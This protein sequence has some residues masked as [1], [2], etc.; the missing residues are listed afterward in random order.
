MFSS[1]SFHILLKNVEVLSGLSNIFVSPGVCVFGGRGHM[2][3]LV[4][5]CGMW[6]VCVCGVCGVFVVCVQCLCLVCVYGVGGVCVWC[7]YTVWCV[8]GVCLS[9]DLRTEKWGAPILLFSSFLSPHLSGV[10][11]DPRGQ[12]GPAHT[13]CV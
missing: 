8:Y 1:I 4:C 5:V 12:M 2:F 3:F 13:E 10:D 6:Y 11:T 9:G 7:V